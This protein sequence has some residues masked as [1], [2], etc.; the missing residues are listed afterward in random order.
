M[1]HKNYTTQWETVHY[2]IDEIIPERKSLILLPRLTA[3]HR[4]F[5]KQVVAF[6]TDY[7][8]LKWDAPG[9]AYSRP[10]SLSFTLMDK[11]TW[12]HDI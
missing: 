10:L 4:L 7:N 5:D 2:W 1:D 8:I 6:E 12:L 3:D 9:H 11:A